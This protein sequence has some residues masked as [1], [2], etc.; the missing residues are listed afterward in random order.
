MPLTA[1]FAAEVAGPTSEV[2]SPVTWVVV[3]QML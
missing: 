3:V 1:K 2:D